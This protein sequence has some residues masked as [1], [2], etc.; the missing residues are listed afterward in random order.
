M[1]I[2][3]IPYSAFHNLTSCTHALKNPSNVGCQWYATTDRRVAGRIYL[4][5]DIEAFRYSLL[6]F[7]RSEWTI[8]ESRETLESFDDAEAALIEAMRRESIGKEVTIKDVPFKLRFGRGRNRAADGNA[9]P[10]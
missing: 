8:E 2:E 1:E 9:K 10:Y 6:H 7:A 3:A 5:P 4:D